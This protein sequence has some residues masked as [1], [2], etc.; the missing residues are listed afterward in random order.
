MTSIVLFLLKKFY[1]VRY[2]V[3]EE[4]GRS[5]LIL[6]L[7]IAESNESIL[8]IILDRSSSIPSYSGLINTRFLLQ[9]LHV[10]GL[11]VNSD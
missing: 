9:I 6:S 7:S 4:L 2:L 5:I 11:P 10:P 3:S 8:S 1:P